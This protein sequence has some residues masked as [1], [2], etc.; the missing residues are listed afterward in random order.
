MAALIPGAPINIGKT[1]AT[2]DGSA[3]LLDSNQLE[4]IVG[5]AEYWR[6]YLF[7]PAS[8][9]IYLTQ[10]AR[11]T[12]RG[13]CC[14]P[15]SRRSLTTGARISSYCRWST[16]TMPARKSS[17]RSRHWCRGEQHRPGNSDHHPAE[18][19]A[20]P[21]ASAGRR[22][23]RAAEAEGP[24]PCWLA[25]GVTSGSP[26]RRAGARPDTSG[27]TGRRT[28]TRSKQ[29]GYVLAVL[30]A[31]EGATVTDKSFHRSY[32]GPAAPACSSRRT[33]SRARIS[34]RLAGRTCGRGRMEDAG[35][36]AAQFL[37]ALAGRKMSRVEF[38]GGAHADVWL[39]WEKIG[40]NLPL[41][42]G[43]E[44][45][46]TWVR[47]VEAAGYAVGIYS[48]VNT[49]SRTVGPQ[50]TARK[51]FDGTLRPWW[52]PSYSDTRTP[53]SAFP[54][55]SGRGRCGSTPT[56]ARCR[57]SAAMSTSTSSWGAP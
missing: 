22:A 15:A 13:S 17:S 37:K 47:L 23:S 20:G 36:E 9:V 56:R 57:G 34:A 21:E 39:D 14:R 5:A 31:S 4:L 3:P 33:T 19:S 11:R 2:S 8:S 24:P 25:S 53:T 50:Q 41:D 48:G 7:A 55:R 32:D 26:P 16:A 54:K 10:Q 27:P 12:S 1:A 30:K 18:A 28:G 42:V 44:W 45:V 43:A 6:L 51:R 46:L 38:A 52:V 49:W 35:D 40:T 29:A